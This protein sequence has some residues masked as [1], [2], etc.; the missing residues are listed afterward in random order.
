MKRFFLKVIVLFFTFSLMA[1]NDLY[2]LKQA[3]ANGYGAAEAIISQLDYGYYSGISSVGMLLK[4][5]NSYTLST[6]FSAYENYVIVGA[7]D[8]D[9]TSLKVEVLDSTYYTYATY[10]SHGENIAVVKFSPFRPG[11]YKVKLTLEGCSVSNS[12][13]S[14]VIL[15]KNGVNISF[16]TLAYVLDKIFSDANV[17]NQSTPLLFGNLDACFWGVTLDKDE[18]NVTFEGIDFKF[19]DRTYFFYT[20]WD[21]SVTDLDLKVKVNGQMYYDKVLLDGKILWYRPQSYFEQATMYIEKQSFEPSFIVVYAAA[22]E[23]K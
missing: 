8:E 3:V 23:N 16:S 18:S 2:Y 12:Y 9:V 17:F 21:M 10:Q 20:R 22:T 19:P 6:Y 7:G 11:F 15:R 14:L 4:V 5:G 13:C 1:Q